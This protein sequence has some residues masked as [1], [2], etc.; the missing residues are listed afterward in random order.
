MVEDTEPAAPALA[1]AVVELLCLVATPPTDRV[2][3][4]LRREAPATAAT[5]A[6][7]TGLPA[8][9]VEEELAELTDRDLVRRSGTPTRYRFTDAGAALEPVLD[10]LDD[11]R[12]R[13]G[14]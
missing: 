7:V 9:T 8:A 1:P 3:R 4:G 14:G 11:L 2:L 10:A 13:H 5:L 6:R 12:D